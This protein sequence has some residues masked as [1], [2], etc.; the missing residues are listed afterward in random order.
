M[1]IVV[2]ALEDA[3]YKSWVSEQTS[4]TAP[5]GAADSAGNVQPAVDVSRDYS[6]AE[7]LEAGEKSYITHCSACHM[8][9]G[10]GMPPAFPGLAGSGLSVGDLAAHID[11]VLNGKPGTAMVAY[12]SQLNDLEIASIITYERN[13]WGNDTGDVVQ[14][15]EIRAQR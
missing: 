10:A 6:V 5:S 8:I 13:A 2:V 12:G 9:N 7:L 1:P 3:E 11:I 4:A 14:P 15:A